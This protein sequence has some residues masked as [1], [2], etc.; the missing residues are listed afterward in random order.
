[1]TV[2]PGVVEV[3]AQVGLVVLVVLGG[4]WCVC[5][6][7]GMVWRWEWVVV[8]LEVWEWLGWGWWFVF[9]V[10]GLV[11]CW[12]LVVVVGLCLW[13]LWQVVVG[14]WGWVFVVVGV[15]GAWCCHRVCA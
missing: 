8:G 4:C 10:K 7:S 6:V 3:V 9:G 13:V 14:V 15:V 12:G 1:M 2:V 11:L 5:G